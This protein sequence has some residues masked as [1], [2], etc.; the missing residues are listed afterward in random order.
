M[1]GDG[2][3]HR[4]VMDNL[5]RL[6]VRTQPVHNYLNSSAHHVMDF[7]LLPIR[8]VQNIT[9]EILEDSKKKIQIGMETF[10]NMTSEVIEAQKNQTAEALEELRP[11]KVLEKLNNVTSSLVK[12]HFESLNNMTIDVVK[13]VVEPPLFTFNNTTRTLIEK[14]KNQTQV[15]LVA[16]DQEEPD[17]P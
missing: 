5:K 13:T 4:K 17:N 11:Q 15:V 1:A 2:P 14:Q 12:P 9:T 8:H 6:W 16:Y 10:S 7:L 3:I